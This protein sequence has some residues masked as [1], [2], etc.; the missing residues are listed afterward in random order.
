M[1]VMVAFV[2][3]LRS[4]GSCLPCWSSVSLLVPEETAA[5]SLP[6]SLRS[7]I[8]AAQDRVRE[9]LA[10]AEQEIRE[11][12][13]HL[14]PEETVLAL[15]PATHQGLGLLGC[16]N[17][18]L[19]FLFSGL[20]RRQLLQVDWDTTRALVYDR[21]SRELSAYRTDRDPRAAP[22]LTVRVASLD[23]ATALGRAALR[24]SPAPRLE[25]T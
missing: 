8:A 21:P 11:L 3:V 17:Q 9:G 13:R 5:R 14:R 2:A 4:C 23:D 24:A 12:E 20:I 10:G 19:L 1:L 16:T 7:D 22:A 25:V 6:V 15:T 18:R